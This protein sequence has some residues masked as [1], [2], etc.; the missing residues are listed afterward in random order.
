MTSTPPRKG[1][2][3]LSPPPLSPLPQKYDMRVSFCLIFDSLSSKF[4]TKLMMEIDFSRKFL[5]DPFFFCCCCCCF[6]YQFFLLIRKC[7]SCD[8]S[9]VSTLW[10]TYIIFNICRLGTVSKFWL[11]LIVF[12]SF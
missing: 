6:Y 9:N 5:V 12:N 2:T 4:S 7:I 1:G 11:T 3:L 10:F 8:S